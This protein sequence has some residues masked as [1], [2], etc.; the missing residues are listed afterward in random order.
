[1]K[2]NLIQAISSSILFSIIILLLREI[3]FNEFIKTLDVK[4]VL[5]AI[6][7]FIFNGILFSCVT[8]WQYRKINN[9]EKRK[10]KR[11][12]LQ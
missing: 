8:I 5:S 10:E 4:Y 7:F 12:N 1:M 3:Q 9:I 2:K 11:Q 6:V